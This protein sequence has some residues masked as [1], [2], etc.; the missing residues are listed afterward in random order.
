MKNS[1]ALRNIARFL[2]LA[3]GATAVVS[4]L[5]ACGSNERNRLSNEDTPLVLASDVLDGVFNPFF[6][7]SG[8][9]GEVVGQTQIAMLSGDED[10]QQVSGWNEPCVSFA[11]S[12]FVNGN[13]SMHVGDDYGNYWTDYYFALKDDIKFSDGTLLTKDDVLFNI[14]MYLDPAY[15]GSSTMYSVKIKGLQEYRTQQE[16]GSSGSSSIES[17][18][19]SEANR[20]IDRIRQWCDDDFSDWSAESVAQ[21]EIYGTDDPVFVNDV[22]Q[23][24][25]YFREE[26]TNTWTRCMGVDARK[27]Y[28][29]YKDRDGKQ[30]I[31][32]NWQVFLYNYGVWQIVL[33]KGVN[34]QADYYRLEDSG[35]TTGSN[36]DKDRFINYVFNSMLGEREKATDTYKANLLSI[37]TYYSTSDNLFQYV[38]SN[39]IERELGGDMQFKTVTGV[40][41][42]KMSAIPT[43][44]DASGSGNAT[45][46]IKL[47]DRD[48]NQKEYDVLHIRI[49]GEDPKAI[50]NF[51]FVVAPGHYYSRTWDQAV[52]D[53]EY[54]GVEYSSVDYMESVRVKQVP[55]GAGPYR[56]TTENGSSSTANIAKSDFFKD[57][58]VYLERNDY[59]CMGAPVI[60]KLRFKVVAGNLLYDSVKS[61]EVHYATPNMERETIQKLNADSDLHSANAL[62]LGYGYIG[63]SARYIHDINIRRAIMATLDPEMCVNYYGGTNYAS[64]IYRPMSKTLSDYYPSHLTQGYY[65]EKNSKLDEN[66]KMVFSEEMAADAARKFLEDA[67]CRPDRSDPTKLVDKNGDRLKYTFTIAGDT[68]DHP[69]N[70][71]L[72]KSAK[73]LND[74]GMDITV[75]HDSQAL[76]KLSSGELTVWAAAWSSSSDP[77]MYQ[78]YHKNS[79]ATSTRA[80][81]YNYIKTQSAQDDRGEQLGILDDLTDLIE[82]GREVTAVEARQPIYYAALDKLMELAVEFPTYQRNVYYVWRAETFDESTIFTGT[83]DAN[84]KSDV[85]SYQS[86]L[87]EIW[88]VSFNEG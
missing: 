37:I 84:G 6:Y 48:G 23:V 69:A 59:F 16:Q 51:G 19:D 2:C 85:T 82:Q 26:V 53:P 58:I 72:T 67:G 24:D 28:E 44:T 3:V 54:F 78:V 25:K 64:V 17:Y 27:E 76:I 32:E 50:Q 79:S 5:A 71:M 20:R 83:K 47:T 7:T 45:S 8:S 36:N 34:G 1:K 68:D 22:N 14:Y 87:S 11:H 31:T 29:K 33:E 39:I 66:G 81:G 13:S 43:G 21:Y 9:D 4:P 56:A 61:G 75:A 30:L 15:T 41:V 88:R 52:S 38:R 77:D 74:I 12:K 86:P 62:N 57:N 49:D 46:E 65:A 55:L 73:I 60:K 42:K 70:S 18:Y 35:I 80:W 10:G 40:E 63:V